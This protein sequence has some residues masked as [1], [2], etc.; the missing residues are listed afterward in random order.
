VSERGRKALV[1]R[2]FF[3]DRERVALYLAADGKCTRCGAELE[4][5]WHADHVDPYRNGGTTRL[6]NGQAL[7]PDCNRKKGPEPM[8]YRDTFD[9]RPFQ[10]AV[11]DAVMDGMASGRRLTLVN[12]GPGS[13][14]TLAY[15]AAL[16][17]LHRNRLIDFGL[18]T[19]PRI[20]LARQCETKWLT[21]DPDTGET[22]GDHR[23]FDSRGRFGQI[24]HTPNRLPIIPPNRLG[25]GVVT[26]Y[27]SLVNA[28]GESI[29]TEW[30]EENKGRFLLVADEAQFC[31]APNDEHSGGTRAGALIEQLHAHSAHTLLLTGTP[32]RSDGSPLVLA[33]PDYYGE[34]NDAGRR[35]LL[36]HVTASY[37]DGVSEG[38]LRPFEAVLQNA[39]VRW[40]AVTNDVH[41][42]DLSSSG[43][44]LRE[45]LRYPDVWQPIVDQAVELL[46]QK[47]RIDPS[48]RGL[49]SCMEQQDARRAYDYIRRAHPDMQ[50]RIAVSDDGKDAEVAL[51][52][53]GT[54]AKTADIL[55]TVRKAFIG[56]DCQQITVVGVLTNYRDHGHL[57]Q[58]VGRGLRMWNGTATVAQ[59][60]V[61]VAPDDPDMQSFIDFMRDESEAGMRER[62]TRREAQEAREPV[63]PQELGGV[64][65]AKA[66]THRAISEDAEVGHEDLL[67]IETQKAEHGLV[68]DAT[69]LFKLIK[70]YREEPPA[71]QPEPMA[72]SGA[73]AKSEQEQILEVRKRTNEAIGK[74]LA[75]AGFYSKMPNYQVVVAKLTAAVNREAGV[76]SAKDVWTL[77]EAN[78][79]LAAVAS[80]AGV[81]WLP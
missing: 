74:Y 38:Y 20:I 10:R 62:A 56:Y 7:C 41:E 31:G 57:M 33:Y 40:R 22:R 6:S 8:T 28:T 80:L 55:V 59:S 69:K 27:S 25:V 65:S 4:P 48:Y 15:Q 75:S 12:A 71:P 81:G 42:Y 67:W 51:R 23:L 5:G 79:R 35:P 77:E 14:K 73:P 53:F 21:R 9:P 66:T 30:A 68:D 54:E 52:E 29:F 39:R 78:R 34:P 44:D 18:V 3:N 70:G 36:A 63:T 17:E 72:P 19:V 60:C 16:N 45:V 49:I 61:V 1:E 76:S 43:A 2:R 11:I 37:R 13:G 47:Q 26:T 32:Y 50:L 58:L 24:R 64:E 46:R